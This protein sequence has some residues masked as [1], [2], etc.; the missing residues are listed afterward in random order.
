MVVGYPGTK[1]NKQKYAVLTL[2]LLSQQQVECTTKKSGITI[3]PI[4][5]SSDKTQLTTFRNKLAYPVYMTIGNLPKH[6]RR[7]PSRQGQILLAYLPTSKLQHIPNKAARRRAVANLFHACL[8]FLLKPLET[9]GVTGLLMESGDGAVH[10]CHPLFAAFAGDY[11]EQILATCTTTG[12]CPTC[13]APR[14]ELGD[15]ASVGMPCELGPILDALDAVTNGP[16]EFSRACQRVGIKPIQQPFWKDLPFVNIFRSITPDVLHQLY[17]GNIKHL[18]GWIQDACGATEIDARCCRLPPNHNIR[19]F[20]KGISHLSRVTGTEHDSQ[21]CR[22]LLGLLIDIQIPNAVRGA[23]SRLI[24][25]VRG[26]L[27]FLYLANYPVHTTETLDQMEIALQMYQENRRIFI[28]LG[29]RNDF[30][31]PKD[32][33][34]NHYRELFELFGTADNFNTEYTERLHI[35]LA[36]E[37][38]RASN[39][40]DEYPQMTAW[41]NRREKVLL[42]EKFIRR[43][44]QPNHW[45][46]QPPPRIPPLVLP[47]EVQMATRPSVSS[48][49]CGKCNKVIE[50]C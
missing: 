20:L 42:H 10:D 45:W 23:T 25:A 17:Q 35:D 7:K 12:G 46:T 24:R 13:P 44:F 30:N 39:S 16:T 3:I 41:L 5:I 40:K 48:V 21:I 18:L 28:E 9:L 11:P 29:I 6:I 2:F 22:F 49:N 32:H 19:L 27:H 43:R 36:K 37:A 34:L 33:F 8:G 50:G 47:R 1:L 38:F 15:P 14:D 31:F 26:L 4:I